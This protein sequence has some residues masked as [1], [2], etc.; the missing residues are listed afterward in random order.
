MTIIRLF[1]TFSKTACIQAMYRDVREPMKPRHI[2]IL[3][4]DGIMGLDLVGPME[5]FASAHVTRQRQAGNL[6]SSH[7]SC[8]GGEDLSLRIR[9]HDYRGKEPR[10]TFEMSTHCS[11]RRQRLA[12][13][14]RPTK[15]HGLVA[16]I[17]GLDATDRVDL[18][19]NLWPRPVGIV[20]RP[21]GRDAL[22]VHLQ[23][24][25]SVIRR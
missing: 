15:A 14:K 20:E 22:E 19:G 2:V 21:K 13:I 10:R 3:G 25:R 7:H 23:I 17:S 16:P 24:W 8:A 4:Y 6:L 5:A 11:S 1:R 9:A 18:H 12:R